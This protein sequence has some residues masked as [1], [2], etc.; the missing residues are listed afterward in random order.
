VRLDTRQALEEGLFLV[1]KGADSM[2]GFKNVGSGRINQLW[3]P[4]GVK[5]GIRRWL[6]RISKKKGNGQTKKDDGK[7]LESD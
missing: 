1:R 2:D 5:K 3:A 6:G 7:K 4:K